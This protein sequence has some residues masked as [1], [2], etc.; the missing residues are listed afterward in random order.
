M[1][2][3]DTLFHFDEYAG[4]LTSAIVSAKPQFTVGIFG[5]WGSGKTTLLNRIESELTKKGDDVLIVPFD[6]WRYQ[7]EEHMVLPIL[8]TLK[9]VLKKEEGAFHKLFNT[10]G[11]T[12]CHLRIRINAAR[13]SPRV[14][15][16][17]TLNV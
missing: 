16:K 6:A 17:S 11:N 4:V 10:I 12:G 15:G 7:H 14:Y 1:P 2:E 13:R 8:E 3:P 9:D 5:P